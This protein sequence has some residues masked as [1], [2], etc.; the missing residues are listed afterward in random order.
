MGRLCFVAKG[1]VRLAT[2]RRR[3]QWSVRAAAV[4]RSDTGSDANVGGAA[5]LVLAGFGLSANTP[6]VSRRECFGGSVVSALSGSLVQP[7]EVASR[8]TS[9]GQIDGSRKRSLSR[10]AMERDE[11]VSV[12]S[13][14]RA[15]GTE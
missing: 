15:A 4:L 9:R 1:L 5:A 6:H 2:V 13:G 3:K 7:H 12:P 14:N 11:G 8:R 10:L